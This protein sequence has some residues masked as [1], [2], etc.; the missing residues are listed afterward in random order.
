MV[1]HRSNFGAENMPTTVEGSAHD[2]LTDAFRPVGINRL[3][4]EMDAGTRPAN[5]IGAIRSFRYGT[6]IKPGPIKREDI[7]H[8]V[9][10]GWLLFG[11]SCRWPIEAVTAV[12]ESPP[13]IDGKII[14]TPA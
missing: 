7:Y 13:D 14:P 9:A 11:R 8:F 10:I 3:G 12:M 6:H 2:F 5:V 4:A 1:L